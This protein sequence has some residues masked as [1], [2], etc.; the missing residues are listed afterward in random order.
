MSEI[1]RDHTR[2]HRAL[3]RQVAEVLDGADVHDMDAAV[4][5]WERRVLLGDPHDGRALPIHVP[6]G[7]CNGEEV[8]AWRGRDVALPPPSR[9]P[10]RCRHLARPEGARAP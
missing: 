4:L 8:L 1:T 3:G 10:G 9:P 5:G 6:G 2:T 7:V